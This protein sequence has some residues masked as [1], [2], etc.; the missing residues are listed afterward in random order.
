MD[1]VDDRRS[2]A[3]QSYGL[4]RV[5]ASDAKDG[6]AQSGFRKWVCRHV[7]PDQ[8]LLLESRILVEP[9][10]ILSRIFRVWAWISI[11][12]SLLLSP[13]RLP[14]R[15]TVLWFQWAKLSSFSSTECTVKNVQAKVTSLRYSARCEEVVI[16]DGLWWNAATFG[17][18]RS[19][20]SLYRSL[21][22]PT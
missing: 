6:H 13:L 14:I 1:D 9:L 11:R 19:A 10:W 20:K 16:F 22:A 5:G 12:L 15:R 3:V 17:R 4:R 2:A 21:I 18:T 8:P 7:R